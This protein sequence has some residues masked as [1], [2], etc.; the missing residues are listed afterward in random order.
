MYNFISFVIFIL[1]AY[2]FFFQRK[3]NVGLHRKNLSIMFLGL[4]LGG[5][6]AAALYLLISNFTQHLPINN[7]VGVLLSGIWIGTTT[8]IVNKK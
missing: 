5:F 4:L 3:R 1:A 6:P 2:L 8:Y 7:L